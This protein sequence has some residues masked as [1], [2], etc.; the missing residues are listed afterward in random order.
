MA[1]NLSAI[2]KSDTDYESLPKLITEPLDDKL[3]KF[4]RQNGIEINPKRIWN[5][6][7]API[8]RDEVNRSLDSTPKVYSD[9]EIDD[10]FA[11]A[12]KGAVPVKKAPQEQKKILYESDIYPHEPV[13]YPYEK[14]PEKPVV[15]PSPTASA[16]PESPVVRPAPNA[17]KRI[18]DWLAR[19]S[20]VSN[21]VLCGVA[22]LG[23]LG[24]GTALALAISNARKRKKEKARG[25]V[26]K[27]DFRNF[28]LNNVVTPVVSMAPD[29][30]MGLTGRAFVPE[31]DLFDRAI[32][33][34]TKGDYR[35]VNKRIRDMFA[36]ARFDRHYS[37]GDN[38]FQWRTPYLV[39]GD[40][41][42]SVTTRN[43]AIGDAIDA[44]AAQNLSEKAQPHMGIVPDQRV[45]ALTFLASSMLPGRAM[46]RPEP[47]IGNMAFTIPFVTG[48]YGLDTGMSKEKMDFS[49]R[50]MT[51]NEGLDQTVI[52]AI[53][54]QAAKY[55]VA[56][57]FVSA[58]VNGGFGDVADKKGFGIARSFWDYAAGAPTPE[59]TNNLK[60]VVQ[61]ID[62][63]GAYARIADMQKESPGFQPRTQEQNRDLH[64]REL[65]RLVDG[66]GKDVFMPRTVLG[67]PM[68]DHPVGGVLPTAERLMPILQEYIKGDKSMANDIRQ[69]IGL[70]AF[71]DLAS[72]GVGK[73]RDRV[74]QTKPRE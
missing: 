6:Y 43:T 17:R 45:A 60:K 61:D 13:I 1:W 44:T 24:L 5:T 35:D 51:G 31:L 21:G 36:K 19:K 47:N 33:A 67:R 66:V 68:M 72:T 41:S 23:A 27:A 40:K 54:Q 49:D 22:A 71:A 69:T 38:M 50:K 8:I 46:Y 12:A 4:V 10:I 25:T 58:F 65:L 56:K 18:A 53:R 62:R 57:N 15:K 11:S 20:N 37:L 16:V 55:P 3:V 59:G 28:M 39:P 64:Y 34:E 14:P 42:N 73:I 7:L 26:K 9:K 52:D 74:N 70:E 29:A 63:T 32:T 2:Q 30:F 48:Q